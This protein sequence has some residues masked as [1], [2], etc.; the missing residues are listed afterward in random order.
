MK[1]IRYIAFSLLALLF[2]VCLVSFIPKTDT[3]AET[4][5]YEA[6]IV[7]GNT[8]LPDYAISSVESA[9]VYGDITCDLFVSSSYSDLF[10][11][12]SYSE[13]EDL[14][15]YQII[16]NFCFSGRERFENYFGIYMSVV[17][18]ANNYITVYD[19]GVY[20]EYYRYAICLWSGNYTVT[21]KNCKFGYAN[22]NAYSCENSDY[23]LD[24]S[25][26]TDASFNLFSYYDSFYGDLYKYLNYDEYSF[27]YNDITGCCQSMSL[28][29]RNSNYVYKTDFEYFYLLPWKLRDNRNSY[30]YDFYFDFSSLSIVVRRP[31]TRINNTLI[32]Y[33]FDYYDGLYSHINYL[34]YTLRRG[35][36][37]YTIYYGDP[38]N[39]PE[40]NLMP[41]SS[42]SLIYN[43]SVQNIIFDEY[44][45]IYIL[46]EKHIPL[47]SDEYVYITAGFDFNFVQYSQPLVA[48]N[49]T[50]NYTFEKP[51]YVD[52]NFSL[53]PFYIP[54]L[55]ICQ[56]AIIFLVFYCPIISDVLALV[57]LDKFLAALLQIVNFVIGFPL[58][59]FVLACIGFIVYYMMLR[60]FMPII[61]DSVGGMYHNSNYY[62]YNNEKKQSKN[63]LKYQKYKD[64]KIY[65]QINKK[66]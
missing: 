13:I 5:T 51:K 7:T 14:K 30:T 4:T 43:E 24:F 46:S 40:E 2:G 44:I 45:S 1:K 49:G 66:K 61:Y 25:S 60:S 54:I 31:T 48:S 55:E 34:N 58:G 16:I 11:F 19:N 52:M 6:E 21:F 18:T 9:T 64:K 41:N 65:R 3:Y 33:N 29:Y 53:Y 36:D 17:I 62:R 39:I 59:S 10:Q 32:L 27:K 56:N 50:Y 8:F 26:D 35:N 28:F 22:S 42:F 38:Y 37:Y 57:Y 20:G 12:Y 23:F 63:D 15:P 47:R